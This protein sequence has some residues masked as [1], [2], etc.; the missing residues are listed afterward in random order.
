MAQLGF[1]CVRS[2]GQIFLRNSTM[3]QTTKLPIFATQ[4]RTVFNPSNPNATHNKIN[5]LI[6]K[7][8]KRVFVFMKGEP[9]S[10][11]CGYSAAVVQIL[12]AYG[13][14]FDSCDV[15]EN[16]DIRQDIKTYSD[17]PTIP[18]VFVNGSFVGGCDILLQMHQSGE[19]KQLFSDGSE[20]KTDDGNELK[21]K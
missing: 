21:S 8:D 16:T 1:N 7:S 12:D 10:P 3:K 6:T 2:V 18:Q 20:S 13:V 9:K 15:L 11:S 19:L 17:W 4:I 14:E 5:D